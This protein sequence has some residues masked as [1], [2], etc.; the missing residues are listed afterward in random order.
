MDFRN[1]K[2]TILLGLLLLGYIIL[3]SFYLDAVPRWDAATYWGA[4][5]KA[6]EATQAITS[7]SALPKVVLD[8][9][10]VFGHSAMGYVGLI[11]IAQL[12]D[13]PN[14]FSL[15]LVHLILATFSVFCSYKIFRWFLPKTEQLPEVLLAT[16]IYA[17]DPLFF[18][19]SIF[20]NTDFPVLVFYT[21][22]LAALLYGRYGWFSLACIMMI[23]SKATGTLFW[24]S[25]VG[26][27]GLYGLIILIQDIT[28][29]HSLSLSR[30]F[31][32]NQQRLNPVLTYRSIAYRITCLLLPGIAYKLYSIAQQG[33]SWVLNSGMKFDSK[34]WNCFGFNPRVMSNRAAEIFILNFHW[35]LLAVTIIALLIGYGRQLERRKNHAVI[36]SYTEDELSITK[37]Q[38]NHWWGLLPVLTGF[39]IFLAF[40]LSY[41]TYIIPRYVVAGGFFLLVFTL[42][43]LQYSSESRK[44]RCAL[45]TII[46]TLFGWQTFRTV[47]PLSIAFFGSTPFSEHRILQIDSP[48]EAQG[49][50]FVY[51]AEFALEDKLLN[52]MQKAI[53]IAKDTIIITWNKDSG[54]SWFTRGDTFVDATTL[55]RTIDTRNSFRYNIIEASSVHSAIAPTKAVYIYM[56][57]LAQFSNEEQELKHLSQFYDIS[58]PEDV[59]FQG[60]SLRLYRLS[61]RTP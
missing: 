5:K 19:S 33:N 8:T 44:L 30:L 32:P 53:P 51:N 61:R 27:I 36:T 23:F 45:L 24:V 37:S 55:E 18:A 28:S 1:H 3:R 29:R 21:A 10:N 4:I 26:G 56:P 54:Y 25:L 20:I 17:L 38:I 59:G 48:G 39:I 34:G 22:A 57:W 15:N 46:F 52:R 12:F 40:N 60:Y 16:A 43:A 49:N 58:A 47:D 50:G 35:I 7:V 42:L 9:Y 13:Y 14:L 11:V 2:E 31:P 6:V 41:I